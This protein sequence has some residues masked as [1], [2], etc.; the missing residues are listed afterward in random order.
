VVKGQLT[1]R[2]SKAALVHGYP[3]SDLEALIPAVL[4]AGAGISDAFAKVPGA[5]PAIEAATAQAFKDAYAYAFQRVFWSTIPFGVL[6]TIAACFVIDPS[7]YL[8]NHV[9]VHME[10]EVVPHEHHTRPAKD[11][12]ER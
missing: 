12:E 10:K 11:C 7:K 1:P 8:T 3:A 9:A 4:S 5:T 2:I 6:A